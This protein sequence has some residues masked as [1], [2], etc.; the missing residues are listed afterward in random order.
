MPLTNLRDFGD[1]CEN[2]IRAK[3]PFIDNLLL[4]VLLGGVMFVYFLKK[5]QMVGRFGAIT[6]LSLFA[7][8]V[9]L[10]YAIMYGMPYWNGAVMR[11]LD[12]VE[13]P[14]DLTRFTEMMVAEGKRF[15]RTR[16]ESDQPFLLVMSLIQVHTALHAAD[17]F[18]GKSRHGSYGDEVS[19]NEFDKNNWVNS[20][21]GTKDSKL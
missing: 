6:L 7:S 19:K 16:S 4:A 9:I 15:I 5:A 2:V 17:P 1:E 8:P 13:Q 18:K 11:N 12:V 21:R 14:I 20:N 10:V 3:L